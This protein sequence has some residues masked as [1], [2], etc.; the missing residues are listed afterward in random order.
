MPGYTAKTRRYRGVRGRQRRA[1]Y[2]RATGKAKI[3][4]IAWVKPTAKN[5]KIQIHSLQKQ[6]NYLK[7]KTSQAFQYTKFN[8]PILQ[9][10]LLPPVARTDEDTEAFNVF[11][12]TQPNQWTE[13]FSTQ[14]TV[15]QQKACLVTNVRIE[16][17]FTPKNSLTPLTQKWVNVWLVALKP[18]AAAQTLNQTNNLTTTANNNGLNAQKQGEFFFTRSSDGPFSSM[19]LLNPRVFKIYQ[20][21]RFQIANI[22]QEEMG[23]EDVAVVDYDRI[24]QRII[25]NQRLG[26]KIATQ[27]GIHGTAETWKDLNQFQCQQTDRLYLITHVGGYAN[28]GD[29][30]VNI[31]PHVTFTVRTVR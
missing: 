3:K 22:T 16:A 2:T 8:M 20:H 6:V 1:R 25:M 29:N 7:K 24:S 27:T 28:D 30:G 15:I 4:T 10:N 31:A 12:L 23:D 14:E 9:E 5:Q 26:T 19:P 21:R 18:E 13:I 11:P 17:W